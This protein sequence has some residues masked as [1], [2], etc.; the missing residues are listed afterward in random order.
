MGTNPDQLTD[1]IAATRDRMT[2]TV[3]EVRERVSP[4][5]AIERRV[6][7]ARRAV[8]DG[9]EAVTDQTRHL[10]DDARKARRQVISTVADTTRDKPLLA[11][12]AAFGAGLLVGALAPS[13]TTE[14]RAARRLQSDIEEPVREA[15]A[16]SAHQVG[17]TVSDRAHQAVDHVRDEA[18]HAVDEVRDEAS[19]AVEAARDRAHDAGEAVRDEVE[20][21]T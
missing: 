1:D 2:G 18:T 20:R 15:M 9:A 12:A 3:Q 5:G 8:S 11:G 13:T 10:A 21:R 14:Q 7:S 19:D 17:D 4:A 16:E 6:D